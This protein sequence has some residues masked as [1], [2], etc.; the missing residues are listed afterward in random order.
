MEHIGIDVH[1][2][3]DGRLEHR[4]ELRLVDHDGALSCA[5]GVARTVCTLRCGA[6]LAL[7]P[8]RDGFETASRR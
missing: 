5:D 6:R 2:W 1:E 8:A 7:G 3:V 4:P